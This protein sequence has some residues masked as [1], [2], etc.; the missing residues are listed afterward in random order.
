MKR[1]NDSDASNGK[2][3][4]KKPR[5]KFGRTQKREITRST[6]RGA[7]LKAPEST[8]GTREDS[9]D[10]FSASDDP[11][12]DDQEDSTIASRRNRVGDSKLAYTALVTLLGAKQGGGK[13]EDEA[14]DNEDDEDDEPV[15]GVKE[16]RDLL[17]EYGGQEVEDDEAQDENDDDHHEEVGEEAEDYDSP[18]TNLHDPF[19]GHFNDESVIADKVAAVEKDNLP[20]RLVSRSA[21]NEEG[22]EYQ[23]LQYGYFKPETENVAGK[24]L[25]QKLRHYNVKQRVQRRFEELEPD[26]GDID[27]ALVESL[28]TY[29]TVD[30]QY[31]THSTLK[32]R[33]QDWYTLHAVN[34][35]MKTSDLVL[36]NNEKK[37][38]VAKQIEA[39]QLDPSAEPEFRDQGYYRPKVVILVPTRNCAWEVVNKLI[40]N[41]GVTNVDNKRKFQDQYYLDY[42]VSAN[43]KAKRPEDFEDMFNGNSND[44]F[45]LGIKLIRRTLKLYC[46]LEHSDIIVASPLGL[47]M[48]IDKT[49]GD[50][51]TSIEVA[52]LDKTEGLSMQN[53]AH[54]SE[55]LAKLNNPPRNF[56]KLKIDFSRVRMWSINDQSP[57]VTQ[58]LTFGR[59][60]TPEVVSI[61][62]KSKNVVGGATLYKSVNDETVVTKCKRNLLRRGLLSPQSPLKHAFHRF[63]VKSVVDAP[64]DRFEFFKSVLVPQMTTKLSYDYGTLLYVPSYIDY[65]RVVDYL[66]RETKV[67]FVAIDEYSSRS[68]ADRNRTLFANASSHARVMVYTE[69]LHF[70][71]RYDIRGVRNVFFYQLPTDPIFYG[72]VVGFLASEKARVEEGNRALE[73]RGEEPVAFDL[74]L[75]T[76][77]AAVSKLDALVLEKVVGLNG[78]REIL[79]REE[80]TY[81]VV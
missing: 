56:D 70:Y 6:A 29:Q 77:K 30:F 2:R 36:G 19:V 76:V 75:S 68:R 53:W 28:L 38:R 9:E 8:Q 43:S 34:H 17:E 72:E 4:P 27:L 21:V 45:T 44:F 39:G 62:K 52:I 3:G 14:D 58:V 24:S 46:K 1:Y 51:L 57:W 54:V 69:R 23:R 65:L 12:S 55:V 40:K 5:M 61:V 49:G 63:A 7:P 81:Q 79:S 31:Y 64:N 35:V 15:E 74:A 71:K 11:D 22:A 20:L 67:P 60:L 41:A 48:L 32:Y 26:M 42:D 13:N 47:K 59:Y 78:C 25:R 18:A 66:E 73:L 10:A 33:Y 80:E 16:T 50:F 37:A